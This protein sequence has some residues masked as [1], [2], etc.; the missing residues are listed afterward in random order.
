MSD[1]DCHIDM[2]AAADDIVQWQLAALELPLSDVRD[3]AAASR[4]GLADC[5]N[6]FND[7]YTENDGYVTPAIVPLV[8]NVVCQAVMTAI[9]TLGA[10]Q[11]TCE[12]ASSN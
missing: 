5:L 6:E 1:Y 12:A 8:S 4:N 9:F 2:Q 11:R 10:A 3:L 7:A